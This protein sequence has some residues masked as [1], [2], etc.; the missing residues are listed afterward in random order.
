MFSSVSGESKTL[1]QV[2][3]G[4]GEGGVKDSLSAVGRQ[5]REFMDAGPTVRYLVDPSYQASRL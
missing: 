2:V 4:V 3:G 5:V 1:S